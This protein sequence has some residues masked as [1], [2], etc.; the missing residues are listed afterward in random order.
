MRTAKSGTAAAS[1]HM[2]RPGHHR[3]THH[4]LHV[5]RGVDDA[6]PVWGVWTRD[7]RDGGVAVSGPLPTVHAAKAKAD[8]RGTN[9]EATQCLP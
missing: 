5:V 1:W 2:V 9:I 4:G 7:P 6:R 8:A 3:N